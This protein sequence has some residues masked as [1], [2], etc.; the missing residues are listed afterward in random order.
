M[1][2]INTSARGVAAYLRWDCP[3]W[4]PLLSR[5]TCGGEGG[6]GWLLGEE[7]ARG[8]GVR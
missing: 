7:F 5:L 8:G 6:E 2:A 1:S 3:T 4:C